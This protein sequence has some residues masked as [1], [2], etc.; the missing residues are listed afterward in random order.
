[1]I[2]IH[3]TGLPNRLQEYLKKVT[4][5]AQVRN[6]ILDNTAAKQTTKNQVRE[7][8]QTVSSE[9]TAAHT[10]AQLVDKQRVGKR[11]SGRVAVTCEQ[12]ELYGFLKIFSEIPSELEQMFL[13]RKR[14]VAKGESLFCEGDL[15]RGVYAVQAG[16]VKSVVRLPHSSEERVLGFALPGELLGMESIRTTHYQTT[17]VALD[18]S[19]V[20]LL[21]FNQL[22]LLEE[23]FPRFQEQLIQVLT[24]HLAQ[25]QQQFVLSSRQSAEERVAAFLLNLADRYARHGLVGHTFRLTMSRQDIASFLGLSMETVSRILQQFQARTLLHATGKQIQL[26]DLP[27]LQAIAHY[28]LTQQI[29]PR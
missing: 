15:F 5:A 28:T 25:R 13:F 12:C 27:G 10:H 14:A 4:I 26:L 2:G 8:D 7:V 20:C 17:A 16:G 19:H 21:P 18:A 6:P 22:D 9:P 1:M 23:R 11:S 29:F 3:C 24:L